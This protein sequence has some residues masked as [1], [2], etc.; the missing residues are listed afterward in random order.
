MIFKFHWYDPLI[1]LFLV[2]RKGKDSLE[3]KKRKSKQG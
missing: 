2:E 1:L 3:T